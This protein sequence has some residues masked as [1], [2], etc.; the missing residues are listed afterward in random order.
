MGFKKNKGP[1][2]IKKGKNFKSSNNMFLNPKICKKK[3]QSVKN[4]Y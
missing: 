1:A 3:S 4:V 2:G